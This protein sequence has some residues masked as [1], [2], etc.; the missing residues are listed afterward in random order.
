MIVGKDSYIVF[1]ITVT[2]CS[3]YSL[4]STKSLLIKY[5]LNVLIEASNNKSSTG[6]AVEKIINDFTL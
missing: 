6:E 1:Y 3:K 4:N 5:F 2:N